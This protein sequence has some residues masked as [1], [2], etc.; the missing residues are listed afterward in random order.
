MLIPAS[1]PYSLLFCSTHNP[2]GATAGKEGAMMKN[3][4]NNYSTDPAKNR[5][6]RIHSASDC[7]YVIQTLK[8]C[9]TGSAC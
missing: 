9:L 8:W 5:T 1:F 3:T 7:M 6:D 4:E 2:V